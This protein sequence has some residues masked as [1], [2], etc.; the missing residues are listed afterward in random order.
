MKVLESSKAL[1][2]LSGGI[3]SAVALWLIKKRFDVYALSFKLNERNSM[4][5]EAA[6]KIFK[7]A[8]VEEHMIIDVGFLREVSE[9]REL[10]E[11]YILK[12][13]NI[14]SIYIPS[15]NTVFFGIASY[16]SEIIGARYIITGHQLSDPFPDSKPRYIKAMNT[17][18]KFGSWLGKDFKTEI[19]MP[20][21][22]FDKKRIVELAIEMDVPIELS[23]SCHKNESVACGKCRGCVSRLEAFEQLGVKDKIKYQE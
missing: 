17:A 16:F 9:L 3:D 13:S 14:P 4:E 6:R 19:Y 21:A 18:L 20:L 1:V 7:K 5:I 23:W 11:N 15:R 12:H 8:D 2:L 22:K 10:K